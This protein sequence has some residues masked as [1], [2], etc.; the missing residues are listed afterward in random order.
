MEAIK[1]AKE[2]ADDKSGVFGPRA[3]LTTAINRLK[4]LVIIP[5]AQ[6]DSAS[7]FP[8]AVRS[9]AKEGPKYDD[10]VAKV[11][12][13]GK[14]DNPYAVC[15]AS[16]GTTKESG[17]FKIK[18]RFKFGEKD[19]AGINDESASK[20][21]P[22]ASP[23]KDSRYR[24]VLIQEGMGNKGDCFYY[25]A[26]ALK[27]AVP[28]FEGQKCY[29][30]HP[31]AID[32][33]SRP[34]R[35][36]RDILGHFENVS[37]KVDD[38]GEQTLLEAD[39]VVSADPS[40]DLGRALIEHALDYSK[41]YPDKEF[42]GL[43]INANGD[44]NPMQIDDLIKQGVP[45]AALPKLNEAKE[46]GIDE[47]KIVSIIDSAISCDLVTAAGAGGK[48]LQMLEKEKTMSKKEKKGAHQE[49]EADQTVPAAESEDEGGEDQD[50]AEMHDPDHADEQQDIELI[51][52]ML[53]KYGIGGDDED[54]DPTEEE[55]E[56]H[57]EAYEAAKE[58]GCEEDEAHKQAAAH[59]KMCKHMAAKKEKEKHE[60]EEEESHHESE[61]EGMDDG[62]DDDDDQQPAAKPAAG[63]KPPM[64]PVPQKQSTK[65]ALIRL[66]AENA[67]L[68]ESLGKM[69]VKGH[70]EKILR[71]SK[72]P[73]TVTQAFRDVLGTPKTVEEVDRAWKLFE[74]GLKK[75]KTVGF[76]SFSES[77]FAVT[78]EK[79]TATR[80]KS[81][82]FDD[83]SK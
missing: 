70:M 7:G 5:H 58:M 46:E 11:K 30:D 21:P 22:A 13:K 83:I 47:V 27:S 81:A 16:L 15:A 38:E 49:D 74:S 61:D 41:K 10:C 37:T 57:K 65:D 50:G 28:V 14:V 2:G 9:G 82:M 54:Y 23:S 75:S 48:V 31:S 19:A 66:K 25:T 62:D 17:K 69:K 43:S 78:P 55:C 8:Q 44:A 76:S 39:L 52:S 32:E 36:V 3:Y 6:A 35:S 73:K 34:E 72:L 60:S 40:F 29:Y 64:K 24:V 80:T 18:T 68:K 77:D 1:G 71:E 20:N 63:K 45:K 51:K 42:I 53:K 56:M 4:P 12:A 59:V 79:T 67:A 33:M 26:E